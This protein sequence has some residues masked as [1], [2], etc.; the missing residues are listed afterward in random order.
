MTFLIH[1]GRQVQQRKCISETEKKKK[2]KNMWMFTFIKK[3]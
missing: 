3:I 2:L 1:D